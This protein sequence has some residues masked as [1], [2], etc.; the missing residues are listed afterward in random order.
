M[1]GIQLNGIPPALPGKEG[2]IQPPADLKVR[3][4]RH[5]EDDTKIRNLAQY[6]RRPIRRMVIDDDDVEL[7]I[8]LLAQG[9]SDRVKYRALTVSNRNHDAR[10][11]WKLLC[12]RRH[13]FESGFQPGTDTFQM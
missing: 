6:L 10:L 4:F 12:R 5:D 3:P 8:R 9:A 11:N 13:G 2:F 1:V 7:K